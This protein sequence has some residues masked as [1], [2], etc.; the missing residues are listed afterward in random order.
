VNHL[1]PRCE[2]CGGAL[3]VFEGHAY[4]PDCT[5]YEPAQATVYRDAIGVPYRPVGLVP[6]SELTPGTPFALPGDTKVY[7][8]APAG[9]PGGELVRL[10]GALYHRPVLLLERNG[11]DDRLVDLVDDQEPPF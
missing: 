7:F 1:T 8:R 5:S 6:Y 9:A 10:L 11:P 4:C 3:E 2:S